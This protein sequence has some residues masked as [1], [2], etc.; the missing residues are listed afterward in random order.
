LQ[1]SKIKSYTVKKRLSIF[2][3]PARK[4]LTK[5]SLAGNNLIIPG[6]GELV[7]DIPA[8]DGKLASLFLQYTSYNSAKKLI[9][10][11]QDLYLVQKILGLD[12]NIA[13]FTI[14]FQLFEQGQLRV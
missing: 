7:N 5:L 2:L 4:S 8:W 6:Q 11:Q 1:A 12:S 9:T 13:N 10:D 3:S 14:K